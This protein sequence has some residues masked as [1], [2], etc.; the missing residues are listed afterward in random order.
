MEDNT[1]YFKRM[2]TII[3]MMKSRH[4]IIVFYRL[5]KPNW[6]MKCKRTYWSCIK[7]GFKHIFKGH[8]IAFIVKKV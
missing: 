8:A 2:K 6:R 7:M 1:A 4:K 3:I 5:Y